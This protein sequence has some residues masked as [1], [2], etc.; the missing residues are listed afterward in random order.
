MD[1]PNY[2]Y[3][4]EH[5]ASCSVLQELGIKYICG[6]KRSCHPCKKCQEESKET[7]TKDTLTESMKLILSK[8]GKIEL[9]TITEQATSFVKSVTKW[10]FTGFQNVPLD[11]QKRRLDI[12]NK[13]E[14]LIEGSRC[15]LCNCFVQIKGKFSG[16]RCPLNKWG[17]ENLGPEYLNQ[18]NPGKCGTCGAR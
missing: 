4:S 17:P 16:E 8:N 9:P 1:C 13:C 5:V 15:G 18:P 11:E 3:I 12:C 10:A 14:M 2:K 7:P 6:P